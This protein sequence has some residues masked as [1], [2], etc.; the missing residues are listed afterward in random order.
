MTPNEMNPDAV[1]AAVGAQGALLVGLH[2]N[3][4]PVHYSDTDSR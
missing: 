2:P 4:A 3:Q 1:D